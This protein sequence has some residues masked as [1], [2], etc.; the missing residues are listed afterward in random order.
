M[1]KK[2]DAKIT[3][4]PKPRVE[5]YHWTKKNRLGLADRPI[6][7]NCSN[8]F[9]M[10]TCTTKGLH[11]QFSPCAM[12]DVISVA[13]GWDKGGRNKSRAAGVREYV[14]IHTWFQPL[15][16]PCPNKL[17]VFIQLHLKIYIYFQLL[18]W[19]TLNKGVGYC[20]NGNIGVRSFYGTL[21]FLSHNLIE[22]K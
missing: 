12:P 16:L 3:H 17:W 6:P 11:F 8:P 1:T 13:G 7:T 18:F 15:S 19:N 5:F 4:S 9:T 22:Y 21:V 14:C 10:S 2:H 20:Y